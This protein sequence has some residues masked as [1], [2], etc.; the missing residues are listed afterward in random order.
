MFFIFALAFSG[1]VLLVSNAAATPIK[2]NLQ[3]L[4]DEAQQPE[5]PYIPA[6]AGWNGP[7]SPSSQQATGEQ[8]HVIEMF[9]N[10]TAAR[11]M[12]NLVM[13]VMVPDPRVFLAFG[14]VIILLR[15]MRSLR[16][17]APAHRPQP[18]EKFDLEIRPAA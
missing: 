5:T 8:F 15:K 9:N 14:C 17:A 11:A 1:A 7:E 10:A 6:R 4:L 13:A 16:E 18:L 3:Q 2:P 12:R